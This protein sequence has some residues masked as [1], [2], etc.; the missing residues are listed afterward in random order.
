MKKNYLY[1]AVAAIAL[2]YAL[3]VNAADAH[4]TIIDMRGTVLI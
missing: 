4:H 3:P 1:C 2:T